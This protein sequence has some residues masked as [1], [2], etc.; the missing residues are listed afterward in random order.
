MP[1]HDRGQPESFLRQM[2]PSSLPGAR[3]CADGGSGERPHGSVRNAGDAVQI[4]RG[5]GRHL[6][7]DARRR[8]RWPAVSRERKHRG[9]S[10]HHGHRQLGI[11][12]PMV[13]GRTEITGVRPGSDR[14]QT[15]VSP[16]HSAIVCVGSPPRRMRT[17]NCTDPTVSS[18][19]SASAAGVFTGLC[20]RKLPFLLPRSS[21]V[22]SFVETTMRA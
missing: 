18:S 11:A 13:G 17:I 3:R 4:R 7:A 20:R 5:H 15:G 2:A 19:R 21:K 10:R 12:Y 16:H 8:S 1:D 9:A 6:R 14:G 22:T